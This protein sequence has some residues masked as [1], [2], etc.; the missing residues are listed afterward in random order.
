VRGPKSTKL[1]LEQAMT[2]PKTMRIGN[3]SMAAQ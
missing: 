1:V 3:K 2:H